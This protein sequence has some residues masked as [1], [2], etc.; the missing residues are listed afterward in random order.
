MAK[1]TRSIKPLS[2]ISYNTEDYLKLKLN[3]LIKNKLIDFWCYIKHKG[4][5]NI[6]TG[7]VEKDHIHLFFTPIVA[8]EKDSIREYF[9]E[10]DPNN[11]TQPLKVM[12][13]RISDF[14]NWCL[15]VLHNE[16]YLHE[17]NEVK[18][19]H[20][21]IKDFVSSDSDIF[22]YFVNDI[23][24]NKYVVK[25]QTIEK[26]IAGSNPLELF[27]D[28]NIKIN[29]VLNASKLYEFSLRNKDDKSNDEK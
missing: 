22:N 26:I 18:Q 3:E 1:L 8:I 23:N 20:Y 24:Y 4:E 7:E 15:Y 25:Y 29:Q 11:I 2:T 10:I 6:L 16:Y 28:G 12:P 9:D 14:E 5:I 13:M 19:Y 27:L 21:N 17:K